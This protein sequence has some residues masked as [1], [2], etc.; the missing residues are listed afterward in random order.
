MGRKGRGKERGGIPPNKKIYTT[1][2][3][4]RGCRTVGFMNKN[5]ISI[6]PHEQQANI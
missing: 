4:G 1:P 6:T 2:L 3:L 5:F